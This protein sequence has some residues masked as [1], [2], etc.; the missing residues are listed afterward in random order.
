MK[1]SNFGSKVRENREKRKAEESNYGYLSLPKD[2]EVFKPREG[3]VKLDFLPYVVTSDN[4]PD[5]DTRREIATKGSLW[6][7][8]PFKVHSNV[9]PNQETVICPTTFGKPCPI[10]EYRKKLANQGVEYDELK[11]LDTS[12]RNLYIVYPGKDDPKLEAKPYIWDVSNFLFQK[13]LDEELDYHE[14]YASFPETDETG[15]TLELRFEEKT[16]NKNKFY[17][18]NRIDFVNRKKGIP[19]SVLEMVPE[20]D[21]VLLMRTYSEL[22]KLM[23]NLEEIE[24]NGD[25]D[26]DDEKPTRNSAKP[27][28]ET[29]NKNYK[30]EEED[31]EED[32]EKPKKEKCPYGHKFGQDN[33]SFPKDCNKCKVWDDCAD[34]E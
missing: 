29:P 15:Y 27:G 32:D 3:L 13:L 31:D 25:E 4:H 24:D 6:Y 12:K 11:K 10:C 17:Q 34:F 1:Q 19:S 21:K 8:L 22:E 23:F 28:K 9:G 26:E 14:Q 5:K 2:I 18:T 20:L 30:R 7:K 16:F 33:D